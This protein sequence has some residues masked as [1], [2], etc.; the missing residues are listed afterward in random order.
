MQL[1]K[2]ELVGA[3]HD[4]GVGGRNVDAGF[5]DGRAQQDIEARLVE[6]AHHQFEFA[7]RHLAVCDTDARLRQ[8]LREAFLHVTD[9]IDLVVQEVHL[10]AAFQFTQCG[11]TDESVADRG[12]ESLDRQ[13]SL[14]RGGDDRKIA[15]AF[16]RHRQCAGNRCRSQ[17]QYV[18]FRAQGL[19]LLLLAHA[20]TVLLVDDGQS[21][22]L[23]FHAARQELVRADGDIDLSP[24]QSFQGGGGILARAK[25]GQLRD[26]YRPVGKAVRESLEMLFREQGGRHE[27][28]N[29]FAVGYGY[30]SRA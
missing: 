27:Y 25:A 23:E 11:F 24:G 17:R 22:I 9:G 18:H 7:F 26:L 8:Q 14:W 10:A 28:R 2:A 3:I 29:L 12:T 15:Q 21:E 4:D 20:E 1:R 30:E 13:P 19:E 16:Q 6:V 5:D